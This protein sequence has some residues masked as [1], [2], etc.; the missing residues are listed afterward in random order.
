LFVGSYHRISASAHRLDIPNVDFGRFNLHFGLY[1]YYK[2][3]IEFGQLSRI[4]LVLLHCQQGS[5]KVASLLLGDRSLLQI[6]RLSFE[7]KGAFF[8]NV[9]LFLQCGS[10]LLRI[11]L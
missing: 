6:V 9:N 1:E 2:L 3:P 8:Y 4:H 10:R 11:D 5:S 7:E